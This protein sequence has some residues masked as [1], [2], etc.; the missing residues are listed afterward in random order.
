[1]FN[2]GADLSQGYVGL[3]RHKDS[4][5]IYATEADRPE[6][7]ARFASANFKGTTLDL[8][9]VVKLDQQA[10]APKTAPT[11]GADVATKGEAMPAPQAAQ[12]ATGASGFNTQAVQQAKAKIAQHSPA[13]AF[14]LKEAEKGGAI[15]QAAAAGIALGLAGVY[16]RVERDEQTQKEMSAKNEKN[17]HQ[18]RQSS[19]RSRGGEEMEL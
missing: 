8:A 1:M 18:A 16:E 3:T 13:G 14:L 11:V 6:M 12:A 4:V 19:A 15:Q 7:A 2:R 10:Q 17:H 5:K 9:T